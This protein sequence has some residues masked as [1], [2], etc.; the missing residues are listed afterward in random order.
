M[1]QGGSSEQEKG[2]TEQEVSDTIK[3]KNLFGLKG[4]AKNMSRK[5]L[6]KGT[7]QGKLLFNLG[8][9][10]VTSGNGPFIKA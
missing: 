6:G 8:G 3:D 1:S 9:G 10:G 2:G 5:L 4:R 7:S